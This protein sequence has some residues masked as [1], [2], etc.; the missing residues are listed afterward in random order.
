MRKLI[1]LRFLKQPKETTASSQLLRRPSCKHTIIWSTR[2]VAAVGCCA[3]VVYS[4]RVYLNYPTYIDVS[5]DAEW[6]T[7]Y[8]LFLCLDSA[9]IFARDEGFNMYNLTNLE[10]TRFLDRTVKEIL[11]GTPSGDTIIKGCSHR[12]VASRRGKIGEIENITDRILFQTDN[13]TECYDHYLV[14]KMVVDS[15]I[16]YSLIPKNYS[17]WSRIALR[18]ALNEESTLYTVMTNASLLTARFSLLA[19]MNDLFPITSSEFAPNLYKDKKYNYYIIS[20]IKYISSFLP[21]PYPNADFVHFMFDRCV[22]TCSSKAFISTNETFSSRFYHSDKRLNVKYFTMKDRQVN[23]TSTR[24][25]RVIERCEKGCLRYNDYMIAEA[26]DSFPITATLVG[27]STIKQLLARDVIVFRLK[28]TNI[29]VYTITFKARISPFEQI[30]N[31]GSIISIWF[32]FSA[33]SL[34]GITRLR[35]SGITAQAL[36]EMDDQLVLLKKIYEFD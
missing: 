19:G 26:L 9:E 35:K 33:I 24:I 30:I 25:K 23:D 1:P 14:E 7:N 18:G 5:Q 16:C 21:T 6:T 11:A 17:G 3:H 4:M 12:G 10:R 36:K 15:L 28:S 2:L 22:S 31:L 29:P 34:A 32:G 8:S 27:T 13:I 20:Y